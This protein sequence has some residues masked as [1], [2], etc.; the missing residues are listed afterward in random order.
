[1]NRGL[2]NMMVF[3]KVLIPRRLRNRASKSI[4]KQSSYQA[5]YGTYCINRKPLL[6]TFVIQLARHTPAKLLSL[7]PS[8]RLQLVATP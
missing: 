6:C 7:R 4:N 1:M 3:G 2:P 5:K 8:R